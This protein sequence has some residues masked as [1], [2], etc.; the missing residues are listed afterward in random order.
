MK[1]SELKKIIKEEIENVLG[2]EK[3]PEMLRGLKLTSVSYGE[4][5]GHSISLSWNGKEISIVDLD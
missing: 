5:R 2:Q 1:T 4:G 3:I